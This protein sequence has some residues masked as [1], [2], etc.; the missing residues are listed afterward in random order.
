MHINPP[1]E[2]VTAFKDRL[3]EDGPTLSDRFSQLDSDGGFNGA[4]ELTKGKAIVQPKKDIYDASKEPLDES[5]STIQDKTPAKRVTS[6]L[7]EVS[8]QD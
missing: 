3:V 5:V 1:R 4:D 8:Q 7:P 6:A 2:E